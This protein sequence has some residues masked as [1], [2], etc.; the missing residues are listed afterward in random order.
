MSVIVLE[1]GS[2]LCGGGM[3]VDLDIKPTSCPNPLNVSGKGVLPVAIL[4]SDELDVNDI[5]L[6]TVQ[7]A[8]VSPLRSSVED[9]TS[10]L[11]DPQEDCECSTAGPDGFEDLTLKFEKQLIVGTLGAVDNGDVITLE[12]TGELLDGTPF[13]ASDCM[14]IIN[15]KK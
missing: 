1:E 4:G 15:K 5:D 2:C 12:I 9:V 7:L 8:G 13:A 3:G 11:E 14:I 10:P 6:A